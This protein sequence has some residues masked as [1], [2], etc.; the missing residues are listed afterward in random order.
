[1]S[2]LFKNLTLFRLPRAY[3]ASLDAQRIDSALAEIPLKE[4]G[5]HEM[6]SAGFVPIPGLGGALTFADCQGR[7]LF[8]IGAFK[9]L[10]PG[11][12]VGAELN[13]RLEQ[14]RAEENREPRGRER[15]RLRDETVLEMMPRAFLMPSQ[16]SGIIDLRS[17]W[18]MLDTASRRIAEAAVSLLRGALDS[19]PALPAQAQHSPRLEF[20]AWLRGDAS[21]SCAGLSIGTT[22]VLEE[23]VEAG[24]RIAA[25][26]QELFCDEISQHLEAG[27]FCTALELHLDRRMGFR[28]DESLTLR[29]IVWHDELLEGLPDSDEEDDAHAAA[30]ATLCMSALAEAVQVIATELD[31]AEVCDA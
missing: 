15:R 9:R 28:I 18:L 30:T 4:P 22:C 31:A 14:I 12:A 8:R 10:L 7:V 11:P 20:T 27:K 17:G 5:P 29:Q 24:A 26:D 25:R 13:A 21:P 6:A 23:C 16:L 19:L 3:C 2:L 1:M